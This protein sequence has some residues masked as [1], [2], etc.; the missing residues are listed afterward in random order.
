M[1]PGRRGADVVLDDAVVLRDLVEQ[2]DEAR[3]GEEAGLLQRQRALDR[4]GDLLE[5]LPLQALDLAAQRERDVGV[6][7]LQEAIDDAFVEGG[8]GRLEPG[9]ARQQDRLDRKIANGAAELDARHFRHVEVDD[10]DGD[11]LVARVVVDH[12]AQLGQ[13]QPQQAVAVAAPRSPDP[14]PSSP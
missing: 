9:L 10:G 2:L 11:A 14:S 7:L 8:D 4:I 5:I 12:R 6:L 3:I 13:L 1:T